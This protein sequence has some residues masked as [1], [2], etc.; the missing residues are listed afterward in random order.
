MHVE[1]HGSEIGHSYRFSW[2]T[3]F[4]NTY[5]HR[6]DPM[7]VDIMQKPLIVELLDL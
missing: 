7:K 2:V 6:N 4:L 3:W 1:K 5:L